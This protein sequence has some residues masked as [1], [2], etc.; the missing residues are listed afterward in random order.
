MA[1]DLSDAQLRKQLMAYGEKNIGPITNTTRAIYRK[2]LNHLKAAQRKVSKGPRSAQTSRKLTALSSDDSEGEVES[3]P[4]APARGRKSRSTRERARGAARDPDQAP[5]AAIRP[6]SPR[7]SL[8]SRRS[9]VPKQEPEQDGSTD[10]EQENDA[11]PYSSPFFSNSSRPSPGIA[12]TGLQV[13]MDNTLNLSK[14]DQPDSIEV[15]DSDHDPTNDTQD[16]VY[17]D[18]LSPVKGTKSV[19]SSP[20]S[21]D[22]S[23]FNRTWARWMGNGDASEGK[24][25]KSRSMSTLESGRFLH[26]RLSHD[27]NTRRNNLP[28]K[29]NKSLLN[30]TKFDSNSV[31]NHVGSSHPKSLKHCDDSVLLS[32]DEMEREFKTEEDPSSYSYALYISK[33]LVIIVALF[34]LGLALVYLTISGPSLNSASELYISDIINSPIL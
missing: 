7:R 12:S 29:Q 14:Y 33:V 26:H 25:P 10:K 1:D 4:L 8:R 15:S 16:D 19:N 31:S 30:D 21:E 24:V 3:K 5:A 18:G 9:F 27:G 6:P 34:F 20:R 28:S 32:E 13:S 22:S 23:F 17:D 11:T 2:K